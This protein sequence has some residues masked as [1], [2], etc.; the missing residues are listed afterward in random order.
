MPFGRFD[1]RVVAQLTSSP[2]VELAIVRGM[3]HYM[4]VAEFV[5]ACVA[6]LANTQHEFAASSAFLR[7]SSWPATGAA[8]KSAAS[9]RDSERPDSGE[10]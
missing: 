8:E 6:V 10:S 5:P 4:E 1:E 9:L 7:L 2:C 3:G